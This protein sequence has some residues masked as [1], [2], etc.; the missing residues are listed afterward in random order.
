MA[1]QDY[2]FVA[3]ELVKVDRAISGFGLEVGSSASQA[4]SVGMLGR[5]CKKAACRRS[6][7]A[8]WG[9]LGLR[10]GTIL[11]LRTHLVKRVGFACY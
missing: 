10:C 2:P 7:G 5:R 8:W 11:G 1:E 9:R 3:N 6:V 4:E